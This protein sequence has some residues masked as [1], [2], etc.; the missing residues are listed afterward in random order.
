[1][2]YVGANDLAPVFVPEFDITLL[3]K[4]IIREGW[5]CLSKRLQVWRLPQH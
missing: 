5:R 3:N 1:M 2:S 4:Y